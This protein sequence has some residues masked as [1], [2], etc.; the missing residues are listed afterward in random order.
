MLPATKHLLQ[1]VGLRRS[2]VPC[3]LLTGVGAGGFYD[4]DLI[5]ANDSNP[6]TICELP[7]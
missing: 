6:S 2:F 1:S 4:F 3:Q 5:K 7:P